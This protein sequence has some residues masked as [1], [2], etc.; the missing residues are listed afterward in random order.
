[1][2][3]LTIE[4]AKKFDLPPEL[5][6][7]IIMTES[8]GIPTATRFEPGFLKRYILQ[9]PGLSTEVRRAR[10][11]SWGLMQVMGEVARGYGY[12]GLYKDLCRP[13]L[14]LYYGCLHL[15]NLKAR[16]FDKWDWPGVIAAYNAGS[17]RTKDGKFV[18]QDYV[19]K[20]YRYWRKY[21]QEMA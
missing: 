2:N 17:P 4:T 6:A 21:D 19:N 13:E 14:G 7:A 5:V 1:M 15:S 11:T 18:N 8:D 3:P 9:I 10:S 16:Y 12:K 20:V